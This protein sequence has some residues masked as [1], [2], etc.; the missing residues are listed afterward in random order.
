MYTHTLS[1][2]HTHTH[3]H[4]GF[5]AT[6]FAEKVA[7]AFIVRI[8]AGRP[9]VKWRV[10][11]DPRGES[12]LTGMSVVRPDQPQRVQVQTVDLFGN[13]LTAGGD[14]VSVVALLEQVCVGV[15]GV[16]GCV[17]KKIMSFLARRAIK[18]Q[19]FLVAVV[20]ILEKYELP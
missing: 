5:L 12:V 13:N 19:I 15:V 1:L 9:R 11:L 7:K 17:M 6:S 20:E 18:Y 14:L 3:T 16:S 10:Q 4:K 2:S 8:P